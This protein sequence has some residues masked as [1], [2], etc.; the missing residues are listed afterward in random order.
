MLSEISHLSLPSYTA[1]PHFPYNTESVVKVKLL[2][3]YDSPK[4]PGRILWADTRTGR[5]IKGNSSN[6]C[7]YAPG[8][9]H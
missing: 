9:G 1:E 4:A 6:T 2:I 7:G 5:R 3:A 8:K